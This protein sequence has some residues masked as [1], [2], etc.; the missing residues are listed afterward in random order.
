MLDFPPVMVSSFVSRVEPGDRHPK[1]DGNQLSVD[2]M[3]VNPY[4]K[5]A[6]GDCG[7]II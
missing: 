6:V 2:W 1:N 3:N 5:S 4:N 7:D